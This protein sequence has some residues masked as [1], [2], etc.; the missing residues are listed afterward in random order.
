M[1]TWL[2]ELVPD[3]W[4]DT[5]SLK[6]YSS[7]HEEQQNADDEHVIFFKQWGGYDLCKENVGTVGDGLDV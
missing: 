7:K 1:Q 3:E 2:Q 4:I 5:A 6:I